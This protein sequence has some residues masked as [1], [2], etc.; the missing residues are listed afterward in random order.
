LIALSTG[1]G[2]NNSSPWELSND[3]TR[4]YTEEKMVDLKQTLSRFL[5]I[6][7]VRL[8]VLVGRDGLLIEGLT[9]DGK[10]DMEAVGAIM[11]TGL[12]TAEALGQEIARGSVVGALMEYEHGLVSVDPLGDFALVVTLFDSAASIGRVR[13]MVKTSRT[14]I[15]EA[16]D[17]A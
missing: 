7:G 6:P 8:A 9:R 11:T 4:N 14:E 10:E 3:D 13:H 2:Y 12:N 1:I 17:I 5:S 16:L 15:L